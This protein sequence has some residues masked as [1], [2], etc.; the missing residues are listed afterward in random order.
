MNYVTTTEAGALD[1]RLL[2]SLSLSAREQLQLSARTIVDTKSCFDPPEE[3]EDSG[4]IRHATENGTPG[5]PVGA[6]T[7]NASAYLTTIEN[8]TAGVLW[9]LTAG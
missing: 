7:V 1:D 8:K 2:Q 3:H 5:S 6:G 9:P 4:A